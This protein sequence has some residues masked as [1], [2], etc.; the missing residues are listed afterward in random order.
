VALPIG[1]GVQG[2]LYLTDTAAD[3]GAFNCIPGFQHKVEGWLKGLPPGADPR[4]Q[5]LSEFG[6]A[7]IAGRAGDLIIWHQE[8]PHGSSPNRAKV[9]RMAQYLKMMPSQWEQNPAWM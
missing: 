6:P 7:P 2:I 4:A 5:D 8:L 3:Q 9:P 1:F